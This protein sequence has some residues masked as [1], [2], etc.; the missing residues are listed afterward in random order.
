MLDAMPNAKPDTRPDTRSTATPTATPIATPEAIPEAMPESIAEASFED[1][2][3]ELFYDAAGEEMYRCGGC[4]REW[5]GFAQC[6]CS[7]YYV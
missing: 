1:P 5:D 6:P 7:M 2:S 4:G 3:V